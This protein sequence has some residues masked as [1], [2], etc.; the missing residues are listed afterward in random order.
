MKNRSM[1]PIRQCILFDPRDHELLDIV[2]EVLGHDSPSAHVKRRLYPVFHPRGIKEMAETRGLR[3]AYAAVR[4]IDSMR[5]GSSEERL[6]ALR[7]LRGE[8]LSAASGPLPINT[9]RVLLQIM[10]ELVRSRGNRAFQLRLAHDFRIAAGGNPRVVRRQLRRYHLLEM[11]EAWNQLTFDDHVHDANTKGRKT[12]AHLIMDAWIKGIRRLRVIYYNHIEAKN[13]A[14][15]MEAAQIMGI[16]L[17]IG[18]EFSVRFR[19]RFIQLI[20]VPRGFPDAPAFLCFLAEEQVMDLMA[21]GR[22]VSRYQQAHVLDT[23]ATFNRIHRQ[24]L[25]RRFG[26]ALP[27][28][29]A[30]EF[31]AFVGPGQAA[32]LHLGKFIHLRLLPLMNRAVADLH[33]AWERMTALEREKARDRIDALNRLEATD[34]VSLYLKPETSPAMSDP[35]RPDDRHRRPQLLDLT[36]RD[37]L[38]RLARLHSGYRITLNLTDLAAED[39]LEILYDGEGLITRLEIFNLKDHINGKTDDIPQIHRLQQAINRGNAI[40]LKQ[41]TR[42]LIGRLEKSPSPGTADRVEKLRSILHDI[43]TF[44]SHYKGTALKS[45][46]GSD[47]TGSSPGFHGMGLAIVDTLPFMARR[48]VRRDVGQSRTLIPMHMTIH[49]RKTY[50]RRTEGGPWSRGFDRFLGVIPLPDGIGTLVRRDWLFLEDSIRMQTPGNIVTLGGLRPETGN[51]FTPPGEPPRARHPKNKNWGLL[52]SRLKNISKALFGFLPAFLTF[53]LT[54]DWWMLA[55]FGALIWFAITGVRNILQSV[56]GGGGWR[57]SP[58]LAW[59]DYIS[60]NRLTDSLLYTGFSVPLLDWLVKSLLLDKALSINT[61]TSPVALYSIM[62]VVNGIYLS[63]HNF[64][65]GLPR[66]AVIGNCFRSLLSI[67]VAIG[68]NLAAGSFIGWTGRTDTE[69]ILQKWAAVIS[70]AASDLVAGFIEGGADRIQNIRIREKDYEEVLE[71]LFEAY[72]QLEL[73]HPETQVLEAVEP[74]GIARERPDTDAA[75]LEKIITIAVLDLLYF[76]MYQPRSRSALQ[77]V[78]GRLS[79]D[80]RQILTRCHLLLKR[81]RDIGRMFIDGI[82]GRNFSRPLAF[83]LERSDEYLSTWAKLVK[84]AGT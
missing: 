75:D 23:L 76:W 73:L 31:L 30:G 33:Q 11:P 71:R 82:V 22:E 26:L 68:I 17:R 21:Q 45:R 40:A 24:E 34:I 59:N 14:E 55:Y 32:L 70:K 48:E 58:L 3:I 10:K 16:T 15:L 39:V 78:L 9:A 25:N 83:F 41:F 4:L 43:A 8:A 74:C 49:P 20:W 5:V 13:A 51:G 53:A 80:E 37:L 67:P 72:S 2:N 47:S 61:A 65:R 1:K 84:E 54:K 79:Q 38:Q 12:A 18:I 63:T 28:L 62:A 69:S 52:N 64:F 6:M 36:P 81:Q 77:S 57:R 50:I 42:D 7:S 66:E 29:D 35:T 56:L 44:Q 60:W 46:I 27:P 19:N